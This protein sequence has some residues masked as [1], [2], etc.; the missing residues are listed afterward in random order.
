M[1]Q[2]TKQA[3]IDASTFDMRKIWCNANSEQFV[4][5]INDDDVPENKRAY[6]YNVYNERASIWSDGYYIA[7]HIDF[8]IKYSIFQKK[9]QIDLHYFALNN[10]EKNF[11][12]K[13][14]CNFRK[15][16]LPT[17]IL[18]AI[19][20]DSVSELEIVRVLNNKKISLGIM[21]AILTYNAGST[22]NFLLKKY[23]DEIFSLRTP[24]EWLFTLCNYFH[25]SA[26]ID[27]IKH[28]EE[29]FPGIVKNTIDPWGN[30]LLWHTFYND[31]VWD[32][33]YKRTINSIQQCLIDLGCDP[34]EK[35]DL[36]LSFNL[37]MENSRDKW[38]SELENE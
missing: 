5:F 9:W 7:E 10:E 14:R 15:N 2:L 33:D 8:A 25:L 36:G 17:Q 26:A 27:F 20:R 19:T 13:S 1:I 21:Y 29:K 4:K 34:D 12:R 38:E 6:L 11:L 16:T 30:D 37:V 32:P 22:I 24:Q 28:I 18:Q 31:E 23:S 3:I 35:N